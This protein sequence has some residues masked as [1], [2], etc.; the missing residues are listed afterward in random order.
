[1]ASEEELIQRLYDRPIEQH[2]QLM[3]ELEARFYPVA[4]PQT[5]TEEALQGSVNRQVDVEMQRR[6]E[7]NQQYDEHAY[8]GIEKERQHVKLSA[9]DVDASVDRLYTESLERKKANQE[10]SNRKYLFD[11]S[12]GIPGKKKTIGGAELKESANRL[13][14]PKKTQYTTQEINKI[15]GLTE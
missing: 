10:A 9:A 14:V 2:K 6:K 15:Y 7:R 1:M 5:I 13:S 8:G 11:Q 4:A 3:E 12:Y